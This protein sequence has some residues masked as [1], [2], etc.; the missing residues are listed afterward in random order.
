MK[1]FLNLLL[2]VV[3]ALAAILFATLNDS[4]ASLDLF[5]IQTAD[6]PLTVW[7]II[8]FA[9]GLLI[10]GSLVYMNMWFGLR[11]RIR[12]HRREQAQQ[13][14]SRPTEVAPAEKDAPA[15]ITHD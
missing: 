8:S 10:G 13:A 14:E 1:R 9:L 3:V 15:A 11:R 5:F 12:E 7:L 2:I 6:R 4:R